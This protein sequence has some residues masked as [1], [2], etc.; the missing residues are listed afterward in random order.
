MKKLLILFFLTL[1]YVCFSQT[2]EIKP[3]T[4]KQLQTPNNATMFFNQPDSTPGMNMGVYGYSTLVSKK[5]LDDNF[6]PYKNA[7]K[8][9][10]LNSK[11]LT[12]IGVL[13]LNGTYTP[14]GNE[15]VGQFYYDTE[16]HTY[17][18]VLENGVKGQAFQEQHIYGKN[19]SGVLIPSGA[20]VSLTTNPGSFNTFELTNLSNE[21]SAKN[22]IGLATQDIGINSF[23]Y[24]TTSGLVNDINTNSL[25]E[26]TTLYVG[27]TVGTLSSS[28]PPA[29]YYT[30]KVG[31]VTRQHLTQ[32]SIEVRSLLIPTLQ[33]LSKVNGTPLTTTGQ[34]PVYNSTNGYFDFTSNISNYPTI[35]QMQ[36]YADSKVSDQS[37]SNLWDGVT[38]VA[39]SKNSI[40]DKISSLEPINYCASS[41]TVNYG[42]LNQGVVG[43][44]CAVGGTDVIIQEIVHNPPFQV[45]LTFNNVSRVNGFKF[46][47][48]YA[49]GATHV[50]HAEAYNYTTSTW[51]YLG[52]V[53]YTTSKQWY[54][55]RFNLPNN[56][57]SNGTVLC[58]L[59]HQD[60]GSNTHQL[61]LDY[62]NVNYGGGGG[63]GYITMASVE[64]I[65]NGNISSTNGQAA[66]NELD[67]EKEPVQTKGNLTESINGLQFDNTRQV[68][69]GSSTL[70]LTSG[71][72]I[73]TTT[74]IS[75]GN[76]A[77]DKKINSIGVSGSSTKTITLTHQDGTT[78][79]ANFTN[80]TLFTTIAISDETTALTTGAAKV[81]FRM[82]I[83][84][85]LTK[86]RASV[87]TAPTG[88][89]L[90]F[91][92]N[93]N[94]TSILSTKLSIDA[95][96]KVSVTAASQPVI[97]DSS[98]LDYSEM[99]IDID[100]VGGTIAGTGAKI[101]IY[102][103]KN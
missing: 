16:K 84:C 97:S 34:F 96:E 45:T 63:S 71:Y 87:T 70:S 15:S 14:T 49:G 78:S 60:T 32:G 21:E 62:A 89:N 92:I 56:Y 43:D 65:P 6:I 19:T 103:I 31:K 59:V 35:T 13:G 58:R 67:T 81:T 79:S 44:L 18:F 85:T 72:T 73:P 76:T 25:T 8:N 100:Q 4:A 46:F 29:N 9:T 53:G 36:T 88:A 52:D 20:P 24:V 26:K 50:I 66:I 95:T 28:Q 90:I 22:F 38:N 7:I 82:P 11:N 80:D 1:S 75:N 102:Y 98:I 74:D 91:D 30:I 17:T 83:A 54:A 27:T 93:E 40:Y 5:K 47:G 57:L 64:N 77:Y 86:V 2:G 51:D 61:I 41:I 39:P 99:T 33:D 10:N 69:G 37:F 55:Y 23:G 68:I 48:R 42:T 94:G 12:N 101:I 3:I